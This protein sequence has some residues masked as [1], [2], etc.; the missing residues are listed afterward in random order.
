MTLSQESKLNALFD[1]M[2]DEEISKL[3][4]NS[5]TWF[6]HY[7]SPYQQIP[8][9]MIASNDQ[10][11]IEFD[12]IQKQPDSLNFMISDAR[13]NL[14]ANAQNIGQLMQGK[15]N[16]SFQFEEASHDQEMVISMLAKSRAM[17]ATLRS[18][19]A[20]G[21]SI[22]TLLQAGINGNDEGFLRAVSIDPTV[23]A[24]PAI[25]D[26][27][28]RAL[29]SKRDVFFLELQNVALNGIS[30]KIGKDHNQL[31]YVLGFLYELALLQ[32]LSNEQRYQLF[33]VDL[34]LY[35]VTGKD[36]EAGLCRFIDR[37]VDNLVL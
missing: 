11:K 13:K 8:F 29:I 7:C 24:H 9:E 17:T 21:Q 18:Q 35:P 32:Q 15:G 4:K 26:R 16:L 25:I 10:M 19:C 22:Y 20:Y 1:L 12:H 14:S 34:S 27:I 2:P 28:S 5:P 33:C 36:P 3:I 37:W 30:K 6:Q 23:Q 31:R